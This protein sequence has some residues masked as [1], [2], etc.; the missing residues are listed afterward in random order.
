VERVL[1]GDTSVAKR[2]LGSKKMSWV[3]VI[4]ILAAV[5]AVLFNGSEAQEVQKT[6]NLRCGGLFSLSHFILPFDLTSAR[7][8]LFTH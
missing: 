4:A 1:G 6:E 5:A 7:I 8:K 2:L 3:L